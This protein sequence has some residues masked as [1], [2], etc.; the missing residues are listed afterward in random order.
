MDTKLNNKIADYIVDFKN[1]I[2]KKT[3]E[4]QLNTKVSSELDELLQYIFEYD[5]LTLTKEDISKRKRIK[6][7]IPTIN[8]C[9]AKRANGE[10]CTR[11]QKEG[12]SFCGTHIKGIP[13]GE[14][15]V[16]SNDEENNTISYDVFAEEIGGIVY[17]LDKL[18]NVFSTEDVMNN[19]QNP[20]VIAQ[21]T[22]Q[23]NEYHI[24]SLG[25]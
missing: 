14:I 21:Y 6:N 5:R 4:L 11:K 17:Y 3:V 9:H 10:Q 16:N 15:A 18:H 12:H 22:Y 8:R 1:S 13:H 24:P 2:K 23:N 20:K 19:I 25:I 7:S